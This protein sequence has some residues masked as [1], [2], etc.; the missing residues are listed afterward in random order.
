MLRLIY[1]DFSKKT[2][3]RVPCLQPD[4]VMTSWTA[5]FHGSSRPGETCKS[6]PHV[7]PLVSAPMT[8]DTTTCI[9][10][11][12]NPVITTE[13]IWRMPAYRESKREKRM[14]GESVRAIITDP[15]V[16]AM[17]FIA[18]IGLGL[19]LEGV[20]EVFA[21][22]Q[23]MPVVFVGVIAIACTAL[24]YWMEKRRKSPFSLFTEPHNKVDVRLCVSYRCLV[25]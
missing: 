20:L 7:C 2:L 17:T 25:G 23:Y 11:L 12:H 5:D 21:Q 16:M 13:D 1:R 4:V 22:S 3:H 18:G 19:L 9:L 15:K 24:V 6:N 14:T 10:A 8:I